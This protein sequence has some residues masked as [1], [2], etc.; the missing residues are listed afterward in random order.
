[1]SI[2]FINIVVNIDE[3]RSGYLTLSTHHGMALLIFPLTLTSLP[4]AVDIL[5]VSVFMKR[6][7]TFFDI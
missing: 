4:K 6:K 7:R 5:K 1:M 2:N 3:G